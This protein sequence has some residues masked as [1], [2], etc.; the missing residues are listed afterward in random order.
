MN[1]TFRIIVSASLC[2]IFNLVSATVFGQSTGFTYQGR[3]MD[4]GTNFNGTGQFQFAL[5]TSTNGAQAT[6]TANMSGVS[7]NEYVASITANLGGSGYT[8]APVVTISGGGGTGASAQANISGGAVTSITMLSPGSGYSSAPTV[9]IAPPA[10]AYTTYWSND[11]TSVN[12]SEPSSAVAVS[13]SQGL[14]TVILGNTA[15]ANMTAIPANVFST[16]TNLQLMIWFNDGVSGFAMLTPVQSVTAIPYAVQALKATSASN[17]SGTLPVAQLSGT[18]PLTQLPAAV[19]TNNAVSTITLNNLNVSGALNLTATFPAITAGGGTLLG[20]DVN[21]NSW[22][23]YTADSHD[24]SSAYANTAVGYE[25]LFANTSGSYNNA[26]GC[27]TLVANLTGFYNTADGF[28]SLFANVSGSG[29]TAVGGEA[30]GDVTSDSG[31]VAVGYQALQTYKA[32]GGAGAPTGTGFGEDTAVGYQSLQANVVGVA[33][34]AI[35][36]RS[37]Q[38]ETNA[39]SDTAMGD[40]ALQNTTIGF[41]NT[42]SGAFSL[43][44]N[45]VGNANTADG[46]QALERNASSYNTAVG[47]QALG[48]NITGSNNIALGSMAG[49]TITGS[50]NIDIGNAGLSTDANIIRIG[51]SQTAAYIAGVINGNGGGLTNINVG[52]LTSAGGAIF[53][54]SNSLANMFIGPSAGNPAADAGEE[55][56]AV[57]SLALKANVGGNYNTASGF[58]ALSDNTIGSENT[59]DGAGA[60]DLDTS[61][62]YNTAVGFQALAVN[63]TGNYNV[64]VGMNALEAANPG[65]DD[66]AIGALALDGNSGISN[67][68]VGYQAGSQLEA[69]EGGNIDIGSPGQSGENNV[70]RIGTSQVSTYIAGTVSDLG[71]VIVGTNG[72]PVSIVQ[73]GQDSMPSS[74]LQETNF[75][76]TFSYPFTYPPKIIFSIAN[77]PSYQGFSDVFAASISSNSVAAF[78]INV[79]RLNGVGWSQSLRIN[80]QAWE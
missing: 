22:A 63:N 38:S 32:P 30:L 74:S 67:I 44:L 73:S 9:T 72:T 29:N 51:S 27:E 71:G 24:T 2:F 35:G 39:Y 52:Q 6:A 11:G 48:V 59:A 40:S 16:V 14:F 13:V 7:P 3:V 78:S 31:L 41:G 21:A 70:T 26:V 79:Y 69:H 76:V 34:T 17:L 77:D 37:L 23:G 19:V 64:A 25:A 43:W 49:N 65:G 45:G 12:G 4:S 46:W 68:A 28:E 66:T 61:G 56:V 20:F 15:L 36:F 8:I 60:L 80:W 54:Y 53:Y 5:V 42:A 55:N 18:V 10:T 47:Y 62:E 33:N 58:G 75:T 1:S 50:S 57:G